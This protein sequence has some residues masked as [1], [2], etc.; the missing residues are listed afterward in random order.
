MATV[1]II[2]PS[3]NGQHLL[4]ECLPALMSQSYSDFDVIV[5]DNGSDDGTVIWLK[6]EFPQVQIIE[7]KVNKD[8]KH[9][10]FSL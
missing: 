8:Q 1:T 4:A 2:I 7:N 5:I 10:T 3:F 9:L 6:N